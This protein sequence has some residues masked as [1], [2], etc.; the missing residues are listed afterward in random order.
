MTE[1]KSTAGREH[2][3]WHAVSKEQFAGENNIQV[4]VS[5]DVIVAGYPHGYYD[6][7]NLFPIVKSGIV[8]SR[9]GANFR[10]MPCFLIDAKLFPGSSGSIV[11][12]KPIDIIVRD[13]QVLSAPDKQFAFLGV[14]S[15][16]PFME[17]RVIDAE[18]I[19]I[20]E[21][22]S[23]NVGIVWYAGLIEEIIESG[24]S[25]TS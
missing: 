18:T 19:I 16:E 3:R 24:V 7:V 6:D 2:L 11:V 17:G 15:A 13:G 25:H 23:F 14:F 8:A 20:T 4:Q 12:S 9:W 22:V 5:D 1:R 10:G 21:K